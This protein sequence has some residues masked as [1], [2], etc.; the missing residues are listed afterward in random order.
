MS[1]LAT[2]L[3]AFAVSVTVV[4]TVEDTVP[5]VWPVVTS[6]T[7]MPGSTHAGVTAKFSVGLEVGVAALAVS[8]SRNDSASLPATGLAALA[9]KVIVVPVVED[10]VPMV[11]PLVVSNTVMPLTIDDGVDAKSS[12]ALEVEVAPLVTAVIVDDALIAPE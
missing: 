2:A 7:A 5:T 1:P 3:F 11:L 6:K 4:P 9:V 10:T 8:V 12:V